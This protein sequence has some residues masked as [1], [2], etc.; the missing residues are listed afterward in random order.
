MRAPVTLSFYILRRFLM[1]VLVAFTV[2]S[3]LV[4]LI[5]GLELVRRTSNKEVPLWDLLSMILLKYPQAVQKMVPFTVLIGAV[6]AYTRL[7]HT[8]ELIVTRSAGVSVWQ[9]LLPSILGAFAIGLMVVGVINPLSSTLIEKYERLEDRYIKGRTSFTSISSNGL[10]LRQRT[11]IEQGSRLDT[12]TIIHADDVIGSDDI[13]LQD[14]TIFVFENEDS[15]IK[16]ID[17]KTARLFTDFWH[18]NDAIITNNDRAVRRFD[19]YFLKTDLTVRDIHQSF[20]SP[21]TI[22]FWELPSFIHT[23][24]KSGFSALEHRL[25]WHQIIQSPVFYA[26]MVI[27]AAIF[28]LRPSRRGRAGLLFTASIFTGFVLYFFTNLVSSLGL[29]GSIPV[30]VAAWIPVVVTLMLGVGV[31]LHMEDG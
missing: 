29:S 6:L 19:E 25:H 7:S 11:S 20:A 3:A 18:L 9:F 26:A 4:F 31:L 10:W 16:R 14:V 23:L 8:Q 28:S 12:E 27:V 17:A 5:D 1:G 13:V 2:F 24:E 22:S 30:A 21:E 15:F